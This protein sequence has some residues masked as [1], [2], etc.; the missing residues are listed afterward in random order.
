MPDANIKRGAD[1]EAVCGCS[2]I[3]RFGR[4]AGREWGSH[5]RRGTRRI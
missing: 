4:G 2:G 5:S 3:S 1:P